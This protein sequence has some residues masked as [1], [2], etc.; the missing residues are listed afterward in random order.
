MGSPTP[1]VGLRRER[2]VLTV[3]LVTGRH[4]VIEGPPGTGKSTLLRSI[5]RDTGQ[6]VVFVEGNAE[7]TPAR[8]VGQFD[9][10]QVLAT[11]YQ[12][13]AFV[14]GPLITAMRTG[15]LLYME[16]LNRVPEE[17]LNVLITVL[18]EGEIAVPRLG[19]VHAGKDFRL[20]AAMNPFDAV[21]TARVSQA[22]ADRMCRVVLGYQDLEGERAIT[23]S[24]SGLAGRWVDLS[25]A[26]TRATREHR[27][28]RMGSS[29]RGAIDLSLVLTGLADLRG[30]ATPTRDTARD[31]AYAALSGRI[32]ITDG[33]DRTAESVIDELLEIHWPADDEESDPAESPDAE[34][35]DDQG[36]APSPGHNPGFQQRSR[37]GREQTSRTQ[38]RQEIAANHPDFADVSPEPGELDVD[39]FEAL[40]AEDPDKAAA[41]LADMAVAT[42]VQL[43]AAARRLA[44]RVF[45]RFGRVGPA[46]ARGT[47]RLGPSRRLDGDLDLDRT[48]EAWDPSSSRRPEEL[49]TRT[50]T[51]HRR[52]VCLV[53]D[54]SG[55]MKGLAVALASVAAAGVVVANENGPPPLQP[56]VI[57][58]GAGV[59]VLQAQGVRR[60]PE[61]LLSDLIA[62]RG[63]G[64]TDL[65]AGLRE[66]SKQLASAVADERMVVLLSD[67]LHTAGDDPAE[68]LGGID[69]LHV[70]VPL[71]GPEAEAAAHPLAQRGG[72]RAQVVARLTDIAPALTRIL[73]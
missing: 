58:F 55:S 30:E 35:S 63:H 27:D 42:D 56:S 69:R 21:G 65:A 25:V 44:G 15:G 1:V 62:L 43:R 36:K 48:I 16:E 49:V 51:A 64:T 38:G 59:K 14:D 41:L 8:L 70:L 31:A 12:P 19:T 2:E 47:R 37:P 29:V 46:K 5:A 28:V 24:V 32:R 73:A 57:A 39:A 9:P 67:C 17:T 20:I 11:G 60:P 4:V 61:E 50:W 66:A 18:T 3:A 40:A 26:L 34:E 45:I 22:I 33:V 71:G 13:D 53:V 72:G 10:S 68:A 52:A 6:E 54:I 7:L 23:A